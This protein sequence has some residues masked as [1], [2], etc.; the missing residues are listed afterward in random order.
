MKAAFKVLLGLAM[1]FSLI[2]VAQADEKKEE[3]KVEKKAEKGK[4]T[5]LTGLLQ[6][7]KCKLKETD[8]C[9]NVLVVTKGDKEVKY[10]F[11]D[12]GKKEK[13][14]KCSGT[15]KAEVTGTVEMKDG[16]NYITHAK[17]KKVTE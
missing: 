5:T 11:K 13:Y 7:G 16:K 8:E 14:H 2:V 12:K 15:Q 10:Y 1:I 6:C 9:S 3:K 4:K 17:V